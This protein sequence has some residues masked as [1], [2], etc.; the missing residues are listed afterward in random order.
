[1]VRIRDARR[2]DA[3]ALVEIYRPYVERSAV[4][5]ELQ[6]P[7]VAEFEDRIIK[8]LGGWA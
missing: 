5:F 4:S 8:A 7:S 2:E 6:S 1:V 3:A